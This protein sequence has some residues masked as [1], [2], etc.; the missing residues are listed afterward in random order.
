MIIMEQFIVVIKFGGRPQEK[1]RE[2][3]ASA[4]GKGES[5]SRQTRLTM[6]DLN[7]LFKV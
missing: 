1:K 4:F 5:A 7:Y 6:E 2:M 3:V